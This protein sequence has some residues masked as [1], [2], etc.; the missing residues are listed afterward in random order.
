MERPVC[1]RKAVKSC[2]GDILCYVYYISLRRRLFTLVMHYSRSKNSLMVP[3]DSNWDDVICGVALFWLVE[4]QA[5]QANHQPTLKV[6]CYLSSRLSE[7]GPDTGSDCSTGT[8]IGCCQSQYPWPFLLK[9]S[10]HCI[11]TVNV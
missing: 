7:A 10:L 8:P 9:T 4:F 1:F 6:K 5:V 2:H 3:A 11:C